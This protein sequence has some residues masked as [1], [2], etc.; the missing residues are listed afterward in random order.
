[1]N[2]NEIEVIACLRMI[3]TFPAFARAVKAAEA[4][5]NPG[6]PNQAQAYGECQ[7][8]IASFT[9]WEVL[10]RAHRY[11]HI[12]QAILDPKSV[13]GCRCPNRECVEARRP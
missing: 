3:D 8:A 13:E 2:I 11:D 9:L 1:M 10:G 4:V 7:S 5:L 6:D 12:S